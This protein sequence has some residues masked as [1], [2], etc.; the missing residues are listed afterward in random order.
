MAEYQQLAELIGPSEE[1]EVPESILRERA[2]SAVDFLVETTHHEDEKRFLSLYLSVVDEAAQNV[3]IEKKNVLRYYLLDKEMV[4]KWLCRIKDFQWQIIKEVEYQ[5]VDYHKSGEPEKAFET[6]ISGLEA[7]IQEVT[8]DMKA[9]FSEHILNG[10]TDAEEKI[11]GQSLKRGFGMGSKKVFRSKNIRSRTEEFEQVLSEAEDKYTAIQQQVLERAEHKMELIRLWDEVRNR[12][13]HFLDELWQRLQNLVVE[14]LQQLHEQVQHSLRNLEDISTEETSERV[15]MLKTMSVSFIRNELEKPIQQAL[16][17]QVL[18]KAAESLFENILLYINKLPR[19]I[20]IITRLDDSPTPPVWD[21]QQVKWRFLSARMLREQMLNKI[22][23]RQYGVEM[24]SDLLKDLKEMENNIDVNLKLA[25]DAGEQAEKQKE[26]PTDIVGKELERILSRTEAIQSQVREDYRSFKEVVRE[27]ED[28]FFKMTEA[29]IFEGNTEEL[30]KIKAKD[31]KKTS[32]VN[33]KTIVDSRWAKAQDQLSVWARFGRKKGNLYLEN[34]QKFLGLRDESINEATRADII[35]FLAETDEKIKELPFIYSRLFDFET[36]V[37]QRFYITNAE[38][39]T[40][41]KKAF[42]QWSQHG[43]ASVAIIGEKGSG[44]STYLSSIIREQFPDYDPIRIEFQETIK[45]EQDLIALIAEGFSLPVTKSIEELIAEIRNQKSR[46]IVVLNNIQNCYVRNIRGYEAM[47]K[48]CYLLSETKKQLFWVVSC[49]FFAWKFLEKV[50]SL[51][52]Y[53]SHIVRVDTLGDEQI[54]EAIMSRHNYSGYM[55][56]FESG[57]SMAKT[58]M[59]RKIADDEE[60]V[61]EYLQEQYFENLANLADGNVSVAMHYW[62]RSIR[63]FDDNY[64]YIQPLQTTHIELIDGANEEVLFALA[65]LIL[66]DTVSAEDLSLILN[67]SIEES[68][69]LLNR[70]KDRGMLKEQDAKYVINHFLYPQ[71]IH[72]LKKRNILY[73]G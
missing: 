47:E 54:E 72:V 31:K 29:L 50:Q 21:H 36:E 51:N 18:S 59:Y 23:F 10:L 32:S 67:M 58:R 69:L 65:A 1:K 40:S 28:R 22:P 12:D 71:I 37:D 14:P 46:A 26:K 19:E 16:E 20:S 45:S 15:Q 33:W 8:D 52:E 70:L 73:F 53:F 55:L 24:L 5:L 60:K 41:F 35:S 30:A 66:H 9:Y 57:E 13:Q 38:W 43:T 56:Q 34:I 27:G 11:Q 64:C 3:S 6:R 7:T 44:K 39:T 4:L 63:K 62:V 68:R 61:Q 2:R 48:L 25:L 42:E 17:R 49:S